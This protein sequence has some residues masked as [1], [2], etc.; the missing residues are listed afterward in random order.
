MELPIV[1]RLKRDLEGLYHELKVRIPKDLQEA[2]AHGDLSE[3]AEY[4]AARARQDFVRA[5]IAQLEERVRQLSLYNLS[6]IPQAVVAYGSRVKLA[7]VEAG[8]VTEYQ[9]V[10]PE[11]VDPAVGCISLHSPLGQALLHKEAGDEVEVVTPQGKRYYQIIS[12]LTLHD[13]NGEGN[14]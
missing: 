6:S 10:F 13:L 7:E 9:I 3:N 14:S 5:R 11:E 8:E 2:A 12:L 1:K 4:E